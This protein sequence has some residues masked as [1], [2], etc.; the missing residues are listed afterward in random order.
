MALRNERVKV[1]FIN[2]LIFKIDLNR[3]LGCKNQMLNEWNTFIKGE[4]NPQNDV[5]LSK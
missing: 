2:M 3:F 5:F 4:L 1:E